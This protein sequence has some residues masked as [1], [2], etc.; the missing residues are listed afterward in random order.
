MAQLPVNRLM[1]AG[2]RSPAGRFA[3]RVL[4]DIRDLELFDRAMTLAAQAFTSVLP[5]LI[6]AGSL[7][8]SLNP[9]ADSA[10]AQNLSLDDRTAELVQ[11]SMP[12]PVD[13]VTLTQVIGV[14]VL[15]V[16][17]TSFARALERCF[18]RIWKTPKASI[19]FA[20]RWL[21]AIVAIVIGAVFVVATRNI[22]RGTEA[23]SV[24]GFIIETAVWS[25]LWWIASWIVINRTVSLRALL[26]GSL[27][28]G[29]G[30]AGASVVGRVYLPGTLA[31]SADQFGVLGLAFSYIGWLFVLM[32]VLLV[33][34]TIGRV[35]HLASIGRLWSRSGEAA[36]A[37]A[38]ANSGVGGV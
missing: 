32:S 8:G 1:R 9:E 24:L 20:W 6:V 16:A 2:V 28:A 14:L 19:R 33:A 34:V 26:P 17:A 37:H 23:M 21:A 13:G 31:S 35:I 10:F 12:Q 25:A 36:G 27:L 3:M 18:R 4:R 29:L 5:V 38:T 15:I 22:V 7:R 30:F 11:Q